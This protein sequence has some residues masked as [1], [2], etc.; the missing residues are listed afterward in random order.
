MCCPV[1][2]YAVVIKKAEEERINE[3][4]TF[5]CVVGVVHMFCGHGMVMFVCGYG[6]IYRLHL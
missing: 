6:C 4:G 1:Q 3:V 5:V 2:A